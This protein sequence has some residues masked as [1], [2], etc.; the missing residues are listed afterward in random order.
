[1]DMNYQKD[2]LHPCMLFYHT[3]DEV[4]FLNEAVLPL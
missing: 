3:E 1:M 4:E 2:Y